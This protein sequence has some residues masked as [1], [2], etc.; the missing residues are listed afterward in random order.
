VIL[1][2]QS[3]IHYEYDPLHLA[4][5][6]R[7]SSSGGLLYDHHYEYDLAGNI[8]KLELCHKVGAVHYSYN[9]NQAITQIEAPSWKEALT[10][11]SVGNIIESKVEDAEG[12]ISTRY[13]YDDLYQL[14][15]EQGN[16][17]HTY[18]FDSTY[19]RLS[20]D[21]VD[22]SINNLNQLIEQGNHKYTYGSEGNLLS[23]Q[24]RDQIT[25]Y[26]YDALDRLIK[27]ETPEST[28]YYL[29]DPF[30][31]R[32]NTHTHY[33]RGY[34]STI[35]YL[36]LGQKEIGCIDS[37][38]EMCQLRILGIGT[39]DS[40]IGAAVALEL[41]GKHFIP[42][43]DH[44][45]NVVSLL[46]STGKPTET[47]RYTAF[48]EEE[49]FGTLINPWRFSSKRVDEETSFIYFGRRYYAP[50]LGRWITPDPKGFDDGPNLYAYVHNSPLIHCDPFGLYSFGEFKTSIRDFSS[51][52]GNRLYSAYNNPRVQGTMQAFGGFAEASF[53]A[54]LTLKTG[55]LAAP[56]GWMCVTHGLDNFTSG[57]RTMYSG[58]Y[59]QTCT[60]QIL[61]SAGISPNLAH[62]IDCVLSMANF[63]GVRGSVSPLAMRLNSSSK[64]AT[65]SQ[66]MKN[67]LELNPYCQGV[68]NLSKTGQNNVRS[69]EGWAN[70]KGWQKFPN[71]DGGP[72]KWG[73][74][75]SAGQRE[76]RLR[77]KPIPSFRS[78]LHKGSNIPR[79]DARLSNNKKDFIN[80]FTSEKG[81]P[82]VG[83]HLPLEHTYY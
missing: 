42:I 72:Q 73:V 9:L 20:K 75:N 33:K 71:P 22:Y 78:G 16:K 79:F 81:G 38:H 10:Y 40:E 83:T 59:Q 17:N 18:T 24:H 8:T 35:T 1:P 34:E 64:T 47:Y 28:I 57:L 32:I 3:A 13:T 30:N 29:Y 6:K 50:N 54:G 2:D 61:Q 31:R 49:R 76:W 21:N 4:H 36:Y 60:S 69:L 25:Q 62:N 39:G 14:I 27:I 52:F 15:S 70:S 80:P 46:D 65:L 55:G 45:G 26:S 19:N 51:D 82:E 7:F 41:Y 53:G 23:D 5:V 77:I 43:H 37:H 66:E 74:I 44:N 58:E 48:G 56:V 68:Q 67:G 12:S 63:G 11:D